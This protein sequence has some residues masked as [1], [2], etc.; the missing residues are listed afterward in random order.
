MLD[1]NQE[2]EALDLLD[3][4]RAPLLR[5]VLME[6]LADR[7]MRH[8]AFALFQRMR[9]SVQLLSCIQNVISHE[10][11]MSALP[12]VMLAGISELTPLR[13]RMLLAIDGDL[14]GAMVD[15]MCG[16]TSA[17]PFERYELSALE[18]RVGRQM[19]DLAFATITETFAPIVP[20]NLQAIAYEN[21][22][23]MLAIA[24]GQ[25]W[26]IAVTGIF[27]TE[28]GSGTIRLIV[29]YS[30]FETL[31]AKIANQSGLL[32]GRGPDVNWT[33]GIEMLSDTTP[34]TLRFE[35]ARAE[36]PLAVF[37]ALK[38][39]DVL[40]VTLWPHAVT[41]AGGVDLFLA[42]YGQQDGYMCC[43]VKVEEEGEIE[44]TEQKERLTGAEKLIEPER[45]ELERLQAQPRGA[46]AITAKAVLD[47]VQVAVAVELGR[48][49]ITVKD[50]RAL[51]HGQ[52][53]QL[54][55]AIGEPLAIFANGQK[56][57]YGEVVAVA[58]D[59]YG[60]RVTAL[61]EDAVTEEEDA[62]P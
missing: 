4:M 57:A 22:T 56:L 28:L 16:A 26:M 17:H 27:E 14:I 53:L 7:F 58:N 37:Q 13:G 30:A 24:D 5:S 11:A 3:P 19:V 44:M 47:R 34:L 59:R 54:D 10:S 33:S 38:P 8:I 18:T 12:E 52:I 48:T 25:D 42:D 45:V 49:Q 2:V 23:G 61:A 55:Q 35:L 36:V 1:A 6:T 32:G 46:A 15:A 31:E 40:P 9:H 41:V 43:R 62:T 50:L 60:V 21:A 39:G 20:L 29:P 51:R